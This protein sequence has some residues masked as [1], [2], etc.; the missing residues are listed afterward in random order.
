MTAS[1]KIQDLDNEI[2]AVLQ[3]HNAH[4][5]IAAALDSGEFGIAYSYIQ[6]VDEYAMLIALQCIALKQEFNLT[7]EELD[8]ALIRGFAYANQ[9]LSKEV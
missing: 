8:S 1:T 5:L 2:S 3:K 9:A 4:G 6:S 7:N